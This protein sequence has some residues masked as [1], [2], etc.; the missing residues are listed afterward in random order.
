MINMAEMLL[1]NVVTDPNRLEINQVMRAC[2]YNFW[3][4]FFHQKLFPPNFEMLKKKCS[5]IRLKIDV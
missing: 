1:L 2:I 3:G 4:Y 5:K